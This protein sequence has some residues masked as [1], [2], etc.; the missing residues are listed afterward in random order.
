VSRIRILFS[1]LILGVAVYVPTACSTKSS[2]SN[3][4]DKIRTSAS[5]PPADAPTFRPVPVTTGPPQGRDPLMEQGAQFM[6]TV[7]DHK[8]R[9]EKNPRDKEALRF[10]GNANFDINRFQAAKAYYERFLEIDPA[11]PEVRTDLATSYY[12]TKDVDSAVREL[13]AVVAQYPDHAA[14]LYNLGLILKQDKGDTPGA[15]KAWEALLQS[16]P[17]HPK[18]AEIRREIEAMKKS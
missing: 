2:S 13:R 18:S 5:S 3:S 16:H 1:I 12:K 14:A 8:R 6:A 11:Q 17:D 15:I 4:S 10:M 9:L 7:M